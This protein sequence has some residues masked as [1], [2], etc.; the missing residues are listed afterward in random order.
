[1]SIIF[2]FQLYLNKTEHKK[3]NK[4]KIQKR[5]N[6]AID[7]NQ[8]NMPLTEHIEICIYTHAHTRLQ[9]IET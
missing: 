6:G 4:W 8:D 9:Q 2:I 1:M 7:E 3:E 5:I